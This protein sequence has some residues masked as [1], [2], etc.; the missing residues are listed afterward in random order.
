MAQAAIIT[1]QDYVI[2]LGKQRGIEDSGTLA[3]LLFH[4]SQVIPQAI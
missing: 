4:Q 1:L 3:F 2:H